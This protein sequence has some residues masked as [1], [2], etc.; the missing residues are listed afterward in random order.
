MADLKPIYYNFDNLDVAFQGAIPQE[1]LN[2]LEAARLDAQ[3]SRQP[4]L[5]EWRSEKMHVAGY[6]APGGYAYRCDTG[7]VGATWFFSRNQSTS[8]WN[9]RVSLK[10][11]ALASMGLGRVRAELY[12]FLEAIGAKISS[13]A[14]SRVDYCMDFLASDIESASGESFMLLPTAFVMHSHTSRTDHE[15]E[16]KQSH[17]VSGRYTSVTCGKMPGRQ[18]IV[19]DKTREIQERQKPEWWNHWNAA[20]E[21]RG[22]PPL[23]GSERVWRVE[24][25]AGKRHL[26]DRWGITSWADLDN[27]L[28][29]LLSCAAAQIRYTNAI[30]TDAERFRWPKHPLWDA[31]QATIASDLNEMTSG[32]E[33]AVIRE[34]RRSELRE[35]MESQI[36]GLLATWTHVTRLSPEPTILAHA[37]ARLV[38]KHVQEN[39]SKFEASLRRSAQ[40]YRFLD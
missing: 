30:T 34:I 20:R 22:L 8:G 35:M 37:A 6:G 1:M 24:I 11:N 40:K 7:P 26:K 32:A 12:R 5:L 9:I 17:G 2:V 3:A 39:R 31:V 13:E 29:D 27:K 16:T 14:I 25:R 28:G 4:E 36:G 21:A 19:Y 23:S 18:V 10:A 38:R 33:P 15:L